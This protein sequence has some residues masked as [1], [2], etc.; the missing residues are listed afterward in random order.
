M[1]DEDAP[2]VTPKA[3]APAPPE[4]A[5]P[6]GGSEEEAPVPSAPPQVETKPKRRAKTKA[7]AGGDRSESRV[8]AEPLPDVK[9]GKEVKEGQKRRKKRRH[10]E[11]KEEEAEVKPEGEVPIDDQ[12]ALIATVEELAPVPEEGP[13]KRRRKRKRHPEES[14]E[15]KEP[16]NGERSDHP[17][18]NNARYGELI[19]GVYQRH[20]PAKL[21]EVESL[22]QKYEGMEAELYHRVCEKYQEKPQD[23]DG[24]ADGEPGGAS[25]KAPPSRVIAGAAWPFEEDEVSVNSESSSSEAP[26]GSNPPEEPPKN[27]LPP[28]GIFDVVGPVDNKSPSS[29]SSKRSGD[30]LMQRF[31]SLTEPSKAPGNG[32]EIPRGDVAPPRPATLPAWAFAPV[33]PPERGTGAAGAERPEFQSNGRNPQE[34]AIP[35]WALPEDAPPGDW[36]SRRYPPSYPGR[37]APGG[38]GPPGWGGKGWGYPGYAALPMQAAPGRSWADNIGSAWAQ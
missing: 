22:L 6:Q 34:P 12:A 5:S 10:T 17:E 31:T 13:P 8:E 4:V 36:G 24:E 16:S 15:I 14:A 3:S 18:V 32:A 33:V 27:S 11:A 19:R 26:K 28:S 21:N 35:A 20:N 30:D 38:P 2:G 23:V 7:R 9:E 1:N 29:P 25:A 37:G